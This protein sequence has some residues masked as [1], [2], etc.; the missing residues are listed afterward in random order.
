MSASPNEIRKALRRLAAARAFPATFCPSEV[1]RA[2]ADDWRPLMEPIRQ[3]AARLIAAG[4]LECL[5]SGSAVEIG[6]ARG[7]VRLRRP[8][9]T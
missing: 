1:A 9:S 7:P 3:E 6:D 2:L 4:E 8:E 5:Q